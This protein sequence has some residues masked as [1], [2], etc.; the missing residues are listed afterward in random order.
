MNGDGKPAGAG[1]VAPSPTDQVRAAPSPTDQVR[2]APSPTDQVRAA[3]SPT[4]Q[5]RAAPSPTDQV[6]V[7]PSPTDQVRVGFLDRLTKWNAY[8]E[9]MLKFIGLVAV[10]I[11]AVVGGWKIFSDSKRGIVVDPVTVQ[12]NAG[13]AAANGVALKAY[14][15][16]QGAKTLAKW[17]KLEFTPPQE[18]TPDIALPGS[19][20]SLKSVI[21]FL[22]ES[23]GIVQRHLHAELLIESG[24]NWRDKAPIPA[25]LDRYIISVE[26]TGSESDR[27]WTT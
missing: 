3:P 13:L 10:Y 25:G 20:I 6:R 7:A 24:T 8:M 12:G 19:G 26:L 21:I 11:L 22:E 5:V 2:A 9:S 17:K 15:I 23:F 1:S 18:S 4:D 16:Q 14:E 27:S